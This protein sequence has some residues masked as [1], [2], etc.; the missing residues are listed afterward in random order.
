MGGETDLLIGGF[1]LYYTLLP[2]NYSS[3]D[4]ARLYS[5][6]SVKLPSFRKEKAEKLIPSKERAEN[7]L[8]FF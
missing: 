4:Y 3:D 2:D 5:E 8:S 7:A 1:M 6:I